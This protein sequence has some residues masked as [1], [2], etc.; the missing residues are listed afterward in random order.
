MPVVVGVKDLACRFP[1]ETSDVETNAFFMGVRGQ[2]V[3]LDIGIH[4]AAR[5]LGVLGVGRDFNGFVAYLAAP[6]AVGDFR[7]GDGVG[8]G[9]R[10]A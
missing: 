10:T 7:V 5:P 8:V 9:V 6:D 4:H 2:K 1:V 3:N